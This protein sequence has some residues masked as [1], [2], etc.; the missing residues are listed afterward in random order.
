[1]NCPTCASVLIERSGKFGPFIC[2]PKGNHG[3]FSIQG[4]EVRFTGAV[5]QMLL[6]SRIKTTLALASISNGIAYQPSFS[7]QMNA[8]LAAWGWNSSDEMSQLAEFALGESGE[9]SV[10]N[11]PEHWSN[12]RPY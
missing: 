12:Q 11:D 7:Q 8:Q 10:D 9:L 5:G 1:M 4:S 6:E 3:S 2:C